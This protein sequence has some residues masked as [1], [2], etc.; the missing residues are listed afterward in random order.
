MPASLADKVALF[1]SRLGATAK[2][3][4]KIL[5]GGKA[6][7]IR[8]EKR[9]GPLYILGN[10]PS[11]RTALD[12]DMEFLCG[13]DTLAVNFAT[14]SPEFNRL[15]PRYYVLADPHFFNDPDD[16]NVRK[17]IGSLSSVAWPMTL[18]I[19]VRATIPPALGSCGNLTIC[20]FN[21]RAVEGFPWF[22]NYMFRHQLGMPRPRNVLI[23]SVMIGMWLGYRQIYLLG[24]DHSWTRTLSVT[25]DNHVVTIQ[26]HFYKE[27]A[28]EEKR[29]HATYQS[30]PMHSILES[31]SIAFK[32]YHRINQY[33]G[34]TGVTILNATPGS[35]IDAFQR[36]SIH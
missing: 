2:S 30:V 24:A 25:D 35:F 8:S 9:G 17:L 32:A 16:V 22:E 5:T 12:S 31:F 1:T 3:A 11:L 21:F 13:Q 7:R 19:P 23:P 28:H 15:R 27:D 34:H 29:V 18:F 6:P 10:G 36:S 14:N 4:V 20:R 33:A 26:P